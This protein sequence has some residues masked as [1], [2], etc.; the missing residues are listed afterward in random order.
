MGALEQLRNITNIV[1]NRQRQ[2]QQDAAWQTETDSGNQVAAY[3]SRGNVGIGTEGS[4]GRFKP[5]VVAP[6]TFVVSTRS[7]QWDT[8][9]YYNP[10]N[11]GGT[12]YTDQIVDTNGLLY[13][14]NGV[15][16]TPN[17]VAVI[18]TISPNKYSPSPFPTNLM[19]YAKHPGFP[20]TNSYDILTVK[21]GLSIPPDS[22]GA[23][24][25][26]QAA[27]AGFTFAV[28]STNSFP[29]NYDLTVQILTTNFEGDLE[30]VLEGMNDLLG[31]LYRYE[32]GTRPG[33][34]TGTSMAAADVSGVLALIQDYFT[35]QF[36]PPLTPSPAL[37]KALLI[38]GARS[39]PGNAL[40]T[41][42][43]VNSQGW[44]LANIQNCVPLG[45]LFNQPDGSSPGSS[46]FVEQNPTSALATGD[47]HTFIVTIDPTTYAQYLQLQATL[48]WTDPPG[49]P[50]A[51]IKLVNNLDL[52][53]TNLDNRRGLL[54]E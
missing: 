44:G 39:L 35:N 31:P 46:F 49:D 19:I 50:A 11:G 15:P 26:I 40:A 43:S 45:G 18:I 20:T 5:D 36:S 21:N 9:A 8:N 17:A 7:Q 2:Y 12:T 48:V 14:N 16:A 51:A 29:V 23:I 33:E 54:R 6:G 28:G 42:N 25:G 52:I 37:M 27:Q 41:T 10:T 34:E 30:S 1:T 22:G 47:S 3:S 32:G 24:S 4:N 13:Y 53:I 38:N